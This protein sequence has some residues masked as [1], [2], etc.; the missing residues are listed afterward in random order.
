[1]AGLFRCMV[2]KEDDK[3]DFVIVCENGH[4]CCLECANTNYF[5][6]GNDKCPECRNKCM[7]AQDG[8]WIRN[9]ALNKVQEDALCVKE[10]SQEKVDAD[11]RP[12]GC[13]FNG[14]KLLKVLNQQREICK[15]KRVRVAKKRPAAVAAIAKLHS[16]RSEEA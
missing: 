3:T 6:Y 5:E 13:L 14:R 1:M 11:C 8:N 15:H 2:C 16:M 7:F 10:E 9:F 4:S 12:G